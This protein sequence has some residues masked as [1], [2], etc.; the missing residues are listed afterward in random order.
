[1]K[2]RGNFKSIG[3]IIVRISPAIPRRKPFFGACWRLYTNRMLMGENLGLCTP[4]SKCCPRNKGPCIPCDHRSSGGSR[5]SLA[6]TMTSVSTFVFMWPPPISVFPLLS[7]DSGLT[8][9]N[10]G[11]SHPQILKYIFKDPFFPHKLIFSGSG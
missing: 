1:M 11:W 6:E 7:L 9:L 8:Q 3:S 4:K 2:F 5:M 10:P